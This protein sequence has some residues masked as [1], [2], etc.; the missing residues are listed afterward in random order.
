MTT[1]VVYGKIIIDHIVDNLGGLTEGVLGGGGPQA[2]WGARLWHEDVHFLSRAGEDLE[3]EFR[4]Q[5]AGLDVSL[6]GITYYAG[7]TTPRDALM[8]Y[9]ADGRSLADARTL[10]VSGGSW[11]H[12]DILPQ[13]IPDSLQHA[14][15]FHLLL[16]SADDPILDT[17]R[18]L[19]RHGAQISLEPLIDVQTWSNT[20]AVMNLVEDVDILCPDWPTAVK[21]AGTNNV[22]SVMAWWKQAGPSVVAVRAGSRGSYVWS[23]DQDGIWYV[24]TF[25]VEVVDQTGA[26]NAYSAALCAGLTAGADAVTAACMGTVAASMA[27]QQVGVPAQSDLLRS[28]A[29]ERL[30]RLTQRP[31]RIS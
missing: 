15:A 30:A 5:L 31:T 22:E 25:N 16:G 14:A 24:P 23:D 2:A 6:D 3:Q 20:D 27:I 8:Q 11:A 7:M 10:G 26:G 21:M 18:T 1:L 13:R 4:A 9:D 12:L 19:R 28:Q 29:R 17:A